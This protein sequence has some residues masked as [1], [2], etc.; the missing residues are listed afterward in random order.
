MAEGPV[1]SHEPPKKV[2]IFSNLRIDK[3]SVAAAVRRHVVAKAL[4]QRLG[5]L[6]NPGVRYTRIVGQAPLGGEVSVQQ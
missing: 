3:L 2:S 5:Q 4:R 1:M 6:V